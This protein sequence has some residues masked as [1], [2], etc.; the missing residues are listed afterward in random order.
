MGYTTSDPDDARTLR[1][2]A[3]RRILEAVDRRPGSGL[4]EL[5][6]ATG[7][8][9]GTIYHH[10]ARL[11]RAG[12]V[13]VEKRGRLRCAFPKGTDQAPPRDHHGRTRR[14]VAAVIQE[15]GPVTVDEVVRVTGLS[16]RVVYHH[17][18]RLIE[19]G[20]AERSRADRTLRPLPGLAAL[21]EDE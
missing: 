11:Q 19:S 7:L 21:L 6:R 8:G 12:L 14:R 5:R 20:L 13:T 9:W 4:S 3:A 1:S 2:A 18:K 17:A 10:L 16:R 15:R